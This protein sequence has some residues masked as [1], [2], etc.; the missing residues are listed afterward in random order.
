MNGVNQIQVKEEVG[1]T[2]AAGLRSILT[3]RSRY[4]NDRGNSR[5]RNSANCHTCI[6]NRALVLST[7]HTNSAVESISRLHD[8][9]IEPFLIS[10]SLVGVDGTTSSTS[11][12]S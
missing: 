5:F 1:L 11:S 6:V 4:C 2:F 7:L 12:L 10:S 3:T 9:G 8:M